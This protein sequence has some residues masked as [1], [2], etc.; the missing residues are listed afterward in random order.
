MWEENKKNKIK[1]NART[2]QNDVNYIKN[3]I[4]MCK[5][6]LWAKTIN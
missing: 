6:K 4:K 2:E 3:M 1:T 5:L